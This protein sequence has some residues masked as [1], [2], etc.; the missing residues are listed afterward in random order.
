MNESSDKVTKDALSLPVDRRLTLV[1]VLLKSLNLPT[2]SDIDAAWAKEA[3]RRVDEIEEGVVK[4]VPGGQV[5][6]KLRRDLKR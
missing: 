2:K 3:E 6:E 1:E 4:A 5:F